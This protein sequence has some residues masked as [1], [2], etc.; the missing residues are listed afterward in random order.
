MHIAHNNLEH[1]HCTFWTNFEL[2]SHCDR[3]IKCCFVFR[4]P[5][6]NASGD[7]FRYAKAIAGYRKTKRRFKWRDIHV[8]CVHYPLCM[9][10]CFRQFNFNLNLP[11]A[12]A[13]VAKHHSK[14][15]LDAEKREKRE[16][17]Q[18]AHCMHMMCS[19]LAKQPNHKCGKA[20]NI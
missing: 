8:V 16:C 4:M 13:I 3:I 5:K 14:S 6:A 18:S 10:H 15:H 9:W 20:A 19:L 1:R 17:Q 11:H 2:Y 12:I 7:I